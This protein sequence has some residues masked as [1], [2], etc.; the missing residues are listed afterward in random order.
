MRACVK[1]TEASDFE[2][3]W[4][5]RREEC[6]LVSA[7]ICTFSTSL[8]V[9]VAVQTNPESEVDASDDDCCRASGGDD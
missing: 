7:L 3:V 1:S 6:K 9:E 2:Y 4:S 5:E 8:G